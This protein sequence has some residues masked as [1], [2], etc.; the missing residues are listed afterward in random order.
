M[1]KDLVKEILLETLAWI[2]K[3][4]GVVNA[5]QKKCDSFTASVKEMCKFSKMKVGF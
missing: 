2:I 4:R 5:P 3:K 1:W